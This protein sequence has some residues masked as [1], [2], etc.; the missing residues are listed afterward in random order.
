VPPDEETKALA[1]GDRQDTA[2]GLH[3]LD[4]DD[5]LFRFSEAV[6][7]ITDAVKRFVEAHR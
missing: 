2:A 4:T 3:L 5:H 6:D 1:L 7:D